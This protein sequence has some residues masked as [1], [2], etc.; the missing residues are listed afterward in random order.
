MYISYLYIFKLIFLRRIV[1]K[2][3]P[4]ILVSLN[5]KITSWCKNLEFPDFQSFRILARFEDQIGR[6]SPLPKMCLSV[7][8]LHVR[9][10]YSIVK[11]DG[12]GVEFKRFFIICGFLAKVTCAIGIPYLWKQ[13]RNSH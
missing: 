4:M 11:P 12:R 8:L 7:G 5:G 2:I 6:L 13:R 3:N 1:I 10:G 9:G